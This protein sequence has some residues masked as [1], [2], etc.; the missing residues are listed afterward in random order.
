MAAIFEI[1]MV[2]GRDWNGSK[3]GREA[4]APVPGVLGRSTIS[5]PQ[6]DGQTSAVNSV[7]D[8]AFI[9]TAELLDRAVAMAGVYPCDM[10][11]ERKAGS[12]EA[13][14]MGGSVKFCFR[15]C[16]CE[17]GAGECYLSYVCRDGQRWYR[18]MEGLGGPEMVK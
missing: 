2:E 16:T 14:Y 1:D 4:H 3:P 11:E 18:T 12:N 8:P 9:D 5:S 10:A 15:S 13:V 6:P 7:M 17:G